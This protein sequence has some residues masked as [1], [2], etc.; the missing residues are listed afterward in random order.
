MPK[1]LN[2]YIAAL[3]LGLLL[4][5]LI[6]FYAS[7]LKSPNTVNVWISNGRCVGLDNS[8]DT[9]AFAFANVV[10]NA[11][12]AIFFG[13]GFQKQVNVSEVRFLS[14][15][16]GIMIWANDSLNAYNYPLVRW[17]PI[18]HGYDIP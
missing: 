16:D 3:L 18:L 1:K 11:T 17:G 8:N 7:Q 5:S 13:E 12:A 15:C 9:A 10:T 4:S 2:K 6:I 14:L